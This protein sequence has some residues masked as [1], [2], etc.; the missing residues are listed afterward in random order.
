MEVVDQATAP[1]Y[2]DDLSMAV[3]SDVLRTI[4]LMTASKLEMAGVAEVMWPEIRGAMF[5][6]SREGVTIQK[7]ALSRASI[8]AAIGYFENMT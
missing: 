6:S 1:V 7:E 4:K 3:G 5:M 8:I 2:V